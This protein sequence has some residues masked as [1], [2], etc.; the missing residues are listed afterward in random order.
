MQINGITC[1]AGVNN[2]GKSTVGKVLFSLV[3]GLTQYQDLFTED[4]YMLIQDRLRLIRMLLSQTDEKN[5]ELISDALLFTRHQD[6]EALFS[7]LEKIKEEIE[8]DDYLYSETDRKKVVQ[9]I[10]QILTVLSQDVESEEVKRNMLERIIVRTF[11]G[12]VSPLHSNNNTV[13]SLSK[14]NEDLLNIEMENNQIIHFKMRQGLPFD[15]AIY[16]ES[17]YVFQ[18]MN[19]YQMVTK[20]SSFLYRR[21]QVSRIPDYIRDLLEKMISKHPAYD[22]VAEKMLEDKKIKNSRKTEEAITDLIGGKML[23]DQKR[24]E[25]IFSAEKIEQPIKMTNVASGI[26]SLSIVQRLLQNGW[27][28]EFSVLIIDEPENHLHPRWQIEFARFLVDLYY[29]VGVRILI[30]SHSPYFI[31]ALDV[32]TKQR[33]MKKETAFY[34]AE[35]SESGTTMKDVTNH[36]EVVFELLSEPLE[37]LEEE[38]L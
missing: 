30:T 24:D 21:S 9:L 31:E 26:K 19:T 16:I 23:F 28:S 4:R 36:L 34:L 25:F 22:S 1:I 27:L 12:Q 3:Y 32:F 2:T 18:F 6:V 5:S 35:I 10:E 17:P 7:L 13:V 11:E 33:E 20:A 29:D 8:N 38:R 15:Q 14:S 37:R